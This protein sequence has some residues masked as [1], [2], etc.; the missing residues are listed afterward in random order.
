MLTPLEEKLA[1]IFVQAFHLDAMPDVDMSFG[2]LGGT[3]LGA[4][5]ALILIRKEIFEH[6]DISL[7][8]LNPTVRQL[9]VVLEQLLM[10]VKSVQVKVEDERQRRE[11][12][13]EEKREGE[14]DRMSQFE[15]R[16]EVLLQKISE[17][18]I[19]G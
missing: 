17:K 7:L 18:V 5:H 3:S 8:L 10:N 12:G 11:G 14:G 9:A 6:M 19:R 4:M 16:M 13:D 1:G 2:Q 15:Q